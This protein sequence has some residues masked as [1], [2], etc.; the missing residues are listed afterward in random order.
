MSF[1]LLFLMLATEKMKR[2]LY[3]STHF[4][5]CGT[6]YG[7]LEFKGHHGLGNTLASDGCALGNLQLWKFRAGGL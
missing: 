3:V 5:S 6:I 4:R 2:Y 1:S 7:A